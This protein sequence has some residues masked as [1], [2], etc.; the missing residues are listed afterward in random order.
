MSYAA[1]AS[2]VDQHARRMLDELQALV[3]IP[4]ISALSEHNDDCVRAAEWLVAQLRDQIGMPN[5]ELIATA[6]KPLV[7]GEWLGLEGQPT[8]LVYGHYDV[9]PVDPLDLWTTPPFE[10]TVRGENLY[11]RG[12]S[13]DKGPTLA[14]LK[15]L[16]VLG[17]LHGRP[18]INI[19]VLLEGEEEA[20]GH[21]IDAYV[22]AHAERLAADAV[23]ILDTGMVA[24]GVPTITYALRGMCYLEIEARGAGRDLHSGMYGGIAPNPLQALAWILADLK[25]RDGQINIP[26]LYAMMR[27]VSEAERAIL[28]RQSAQSEGSLMSSAGLN[29]LPGEAG[30]SAM[31]RKTARPTF[32]VHGI[33]GGFVGEGSKTVIPAVA[34][35][36][37]SLRLVPDQNPV[38]VKELVMAQVQALAPVGIDVTVRDL[39]LGEP[40]GVA[41]DAPVLRTAAQ[42]LEEEF[43]HPTEFVREGGSIP[44]GALF[45]SILHAPVVML[46][47]GLDDDNL[48][49]P[50]E[51]FHIPNYYAAIRSVA[52]FVELLAR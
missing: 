46:G 19:K 36:K 52:R 37:V 25:G 31:E 33:V 7:Y 8:L 13:D 50:N 6:G 45:G 35:A 1:I 28:E 24:K 10:P 32:E 3:A 42:A 34:K 22:R 30:Y 26:G 29:S 27:P 38:R 2:Y 43:N 48:H 15:A 18:P 11:G 14:A 12:A 5:A 40:V 21:A 16:E 51:K 4:S 20:G 39:G 41:L 49:A 17:R 9:Q 44:I 23:L 47:F